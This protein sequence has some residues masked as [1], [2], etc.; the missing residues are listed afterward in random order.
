MSLKIDSFI[1]SFE[2][3]K[4]SEFLIRHKWIN[5][6]KYNKLFTIWHRPEEGNFKYELIIPENNNI[7]YFRETIEKMLFI[8]SDYYNKTPIQ[9]IDDFNQSLHDK[10]KYSLKSEITKNGLIPLNEGIRLLDNTK[11]MIAS[12]FLA[13]NKK[14]RNFLGPRPEII[15]NVLQSVELGQTEEGSFVINIY[16]P[17]DYFIGDESIL[18]EEPSFT[19]KALTLMENVT[20]SLIEKIGEYGE[21]N[22]LEIFDSCIEKGLSSNFCHAISEISLN[23]QNDV[24][25][26]IEYF[27]GVDKD[28]EIKKIVVD[29]S[30]IPIINAVE[31]Y[32]HSDLTE[33]GYEIKG[34]VTMLRKEPDAVDGEITVAAWVDEKLRRV[35]MHL[36]P[37][38][39][40]I[41]VQAHRDNIM[42]VC[43]GTLSIQDRTT[44]L[45][46]VTNVLLEAEI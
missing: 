39:Y 4:F 29:K 11:E 34:F 33:E 40:S 12:S 42:L 14:R 1:S 36:N 35:R 20:N 10:V 30:I 22:N 17:R 13:V 9:I 16:I 32:L 31:Q 44:K 24:I 6:D 38:Q 41:A 27:N 3:T 2:Y 23:G 26:D 19:R 18:F 46:N 7:R 28:I 25:I 8:L 45:L 5:E 15:N 21:T 37:K 43:Y